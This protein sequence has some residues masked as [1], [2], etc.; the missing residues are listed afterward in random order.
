MRRIFTFFFAAILIAVSFESSAQCGGIQYNFNDGTTQGFTGTGALG[1]SGTALKYSGINDGI[2]SLTTPTL[3]L[4]AGATSINFGFTY[5]T[6]SQTTVT[7]INVSVKYVNTSGLLVT[8]PAQSVSLSSPICT[9]V[10]RPSD[11]TTVGASANSY[12]LVFN[13]TVT[14]NGSNGAAT[15]TIDDYRTSST[16]AQIVLPVKFSGFDAKPSSNSVS[17]TWSVGAEENVSGYAVQKSVDGKSFSDIGF[18][19]ASGRSSYNYLDTKVG[20]SVYYRIKSVDADGKYS[21]STVLLVRG[22]STAVLLKAFPTPAVKDVTIQHATATASSLLTISAED[23]RVVKS[24]V[25]SKG[26][27]Q[28]VVNLSSEKA[29]LYLIRYDDGNGQVETLKILKQ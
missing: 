14:G 29:G 27:Q 16:A 18:V 22:A 4:P 25:P 6:G 20:A 2:L 5:S 26:A 1:S 9:S 15:L 24:I 3:T 12:Q 13:F 7:A 19:N 23:G 28:T 11:M 8:G 10:L 21:Y 17:L